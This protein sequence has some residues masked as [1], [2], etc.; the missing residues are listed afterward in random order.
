MERYLEARKL[1]SKRWKA[2]LVRQFSREIGSARGAA[3]YLRAS[4][5]VAND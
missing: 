1:F 5:Q 3:R 4:P 2:Q